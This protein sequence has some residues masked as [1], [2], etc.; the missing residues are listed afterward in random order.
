MKLVIATRGS[1]LAL[2]QSNHIRDRLLADPEVEEVE[3]LV[4]KTTGDKILDVALA[5]VGGKGLFV[6]ELEDALLDG[7][8]HLAVHSMKDVPSVL[9]EGLTLG[10]VPERADPRDAWV[11]PAGAA[12]LRLEELPHGAVVGTSSLRRASQVKARRPDVQIVV[13]RGNVDTRLRK[14]DEGVDGMQAIVLASAGL[15]RL[16]LGARITARFDTGAMLPAVAQGALGIEVRQDDADVAR[17]V[18]RLHDPAVA[19]CV[20][21]ERALLR[22]VEGSCQIPIGGHAVWDGAELALEG[23]V[24]RPDGSELVR[25]AARGP[26]EAA[27]ALGRELGERLLAAGGRAILDDLVGAA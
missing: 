9:P 3:L 14:L 19:A 8:A 12:P 1:A 21:A 25:Q 23:L 18:G 4:L 20:A 15:D 2:W 11:R 22:T 5:K 26:A 27:E 7:R 13:L 10:A 16:G 6:K 17:V 24:A